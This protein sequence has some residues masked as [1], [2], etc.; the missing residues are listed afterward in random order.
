MARGRRAGVI[1]GLAQRE[2]QLLDLL[3]RIT[4]ASATE[5]QAAMEPALSNATIRTL[6]RELER[7]GHVSHIDDCG[8]HLYSPTVSRRVAARSA[9]SRIVDTFFSGSTTSALASLFDEHIDAVDDEQ[10]ERLKALID[11]R[12]SGSARKPTR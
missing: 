1:P 12:R 7:K 3:Y 5:L 10:L 9:F 11:K 2:R 6:L 4:P 8:R